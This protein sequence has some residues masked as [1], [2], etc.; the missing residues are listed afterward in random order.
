M[1]FPIQLYITTF[2]TCICTN[3]MYITQNKHMEAYDTTC[4]LIHRTYDAI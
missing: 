2:T 4:K 1:I 3:K